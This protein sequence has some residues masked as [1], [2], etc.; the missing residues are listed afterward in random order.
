MKPK[1]LVTEPIHQVGWNLLAAETEAVAWAGPQA[2]PLAQALEEAQGVIVRSARLPGDVIRGAKQL[3]II[4]KHGAGVEK[5]D[6]AAATACGVVVTSTPAANAQ[7]VAELALALLLSVAR[8]I[9]EY[10]RDLTLGK[11]QL[12]QAYQG[13]ELQGRVL[14]VI[15]LGEIGLRVGRLAG[16]ALGMRV[17]AYDPYRDPWPEGIE[18]V[19][20]LDVLLAEADCLSIHVPLMEETRKLIG[21]AA[22]AWVR[23]TCIL[24]NTSRGEVVD[25]A[26]LAEAIRGGRLA[27]AGLDVVVDEPIRPDHPLAGLPNVLLTPHLGSVTEDGL[28]RMA[29]AAAEEVLRVL[30]G[31]APRYPVNPEGLTRC[32][33]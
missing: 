25:E 1:V 30:Q 15:G 28:M 14:G 18:R 16:G 22:L 10:T 33:R 29:R 24:V 11:P 8:R 6:V 27:G 21:P 31:E 4:A 20:T 19:R 23:P 17:L 3:R 7:S 32:R 5:I 12:R 26:A 13:I 2:A 9:G